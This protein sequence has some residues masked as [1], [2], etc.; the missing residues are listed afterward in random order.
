MRLVHLV[1]PEVHK[2]LLAPVQ[3]NLNPVEDV[4]YQVCQRVPSV[5]LI[6]QILHWF[7]RFDGLGPQGANLRN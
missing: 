6:I 7:L 2:Y 5:R 3:V 1:L 4:L